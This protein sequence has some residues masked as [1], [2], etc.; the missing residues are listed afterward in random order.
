MNFEL[1]KDI[2]EL[3]SY[4]VVV[5]GVP[6]GLYRYR[7]NSIQEQRDREERAYDEVDDKY[8]EFLQICLANPDID[9]FDIEDEE[10]RNLTFESAKKEL[11]AFA[12]LLSVLERVFLMYRYQGEPF[13]IN[14]WLGWDA[15]I[16]N[17]CR[18]KNF[19]AAATELIGTFESDFRSYLQ[20]CLDETCEVTPNT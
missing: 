20:Q 4:V 5:L 8:L 13:R 10:K 18:R 19:R 12:F 1:I 15:Y 16:K 7:K 17:Y 3:L 2:A 6:A 11:I 9:I 14:H